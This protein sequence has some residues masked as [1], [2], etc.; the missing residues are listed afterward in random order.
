[1]AKK[2]KDH[3]HPAIPEL[4][5]D[6]RRGKI[7]RREF[8][9]TVALLGLSAGAAYELAGNVTGRLLIPAA[10]AAMNPNKGGMLKISMR[11]QE[12]TDPATFDWTEKS[13]VARQFVEYLTITGPD[14]VTRPYLCER[15]Q[16]SDDLKTWTLNLR[17]GVKWSNGDEFNADDVV[18]NFKRWLDPKTGS[19]NLGLFSSMVT[20][21]DTGKKDKNGKAIISKSM[22]T[23]AVEKVDSHTVRLHLNRPE[24]AIP[25]NLYNYPTAIVHRR[26]EEEGGNL[27]KNPV[28]TGPFLLKEY[29][30]GQKAVLIKR[31][32]KDY[33]GDEVYLDGITYIDHGDDP[34]AG[35]AA[36][37]S[38][39]V[40]LV[41]ETFVEQIDVV[42]EI[43]TAQ[44]Y[45]AVTAQ[46]GVARMQVDKKPFDDV[47]VRMAVRLC[48]NHQKLLDIAYRGRGAPAEDHHVAPIHPE[49]AKLAM[50][51]QN[52]ERAKQLLKEAGY[53]D[54]IDLKID[55]KKEPPW[56][57]AVAQAFAEMCKPAGIR[58]EINVMPNAQYWEIW[59]KTEFGFTAWTHRPL[60]VMVL[61]LA[62]RSG[63]PWNETHYNNP[64]F[65][66]ALD[67]ASATLDVEERRKHMAILEKMLQQDAI[68]AQPLWRS[69]FAAG[70]KKVQGYRLHP[71]IY[72]QLNKVWIG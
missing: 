29:S 52:Y 11:A 58:I 43:P 24:L 70:S 34:S 47:R 3:V 8:L 39:Q 28:G 15:W 51:K 35:L 42:K 66:K 56:E 13:N 68:I 27:A 23:G 37:A 9:R 32:P 64:E 59:D 61:N 12:M 72:H 46:T 49:Y 63:V 26:F 19:S 48:Q 62:Y 60:G 17:K 25:E 30:V 18:F 7:G 4:A 16:A 69:V 6:L 50:P 65:D 1:M 22:T 31:N 40:D 36:L 20:E 5:E 45:E 53:A 38:G 44:I 33:W 14:N 67:V 2:R 57:V 54:G 10:R 41:Y 21:T 55:C 71:T